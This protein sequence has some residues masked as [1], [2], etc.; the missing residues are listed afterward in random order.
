MSWVNPS[1][2]ALLSLQRAARAYLYGSRKGML[3]TVQAK[4]GRWQALSREA[5]RAMALLTL[6]RSGSARAYLN[7]PARACSCCA[8]RRTI[9]GGGGGGGGGGASCSFWCWCCEL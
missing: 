4:R 9:G 8:R 6:Q 5:K 1:A 2:M 3:C 7:G